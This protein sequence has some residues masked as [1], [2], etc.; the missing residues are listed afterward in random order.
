VAAVDVELVV[1]SA[2]NL[3]EAG[4]DVIE[5]DV[6]R[7][8]DMTGGELGLAPDIEDVEALAARDPGGEVGWLD[9]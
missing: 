8:G 1:R 7:A 9:R 2:R 6:H 5:R 4:T 3:P